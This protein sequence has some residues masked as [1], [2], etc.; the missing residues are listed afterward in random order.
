MDNE[1]E[2]NNIRTTNMENRMEE[3]ADN[4]ETQMSRL[5]TTLADLS[6]TPLSVSGASHATALDS[7][8]EDLERQFLS[9]QQRKPADN[10][11]TYHESG[12][13][14]VTA[15]VGNLN[16]FDSETAAFAYIREQ[17]SK[18]SGPIPTNVYSKGDFVNILFLEFGDMLDRDT[19]VALCRSRR[20]KT[21]C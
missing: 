13:R 1:I 11:N 5:E 16:D 18:M 6:K 3:L 19:A 7:K 4:V 2:D 12:K 8:V 20:V 15:V 21:G 9:L 14:A 17:L 10:A